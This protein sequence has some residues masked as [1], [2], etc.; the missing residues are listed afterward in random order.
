M[1]QVRKEKKSAVNNSR[2]RRTKAQTQEEHT[3][4]NRE[5]KKSVKVCKGNYIDNLAEE[6]EKYAGNET[7]V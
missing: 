6:A 4:A 1:V 7:A 5:V 3:K 2:I